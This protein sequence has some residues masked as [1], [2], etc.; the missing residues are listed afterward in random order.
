[1]AATAFGD[2][3]SGFSFDAIFTMD[4]GSNPSSR[5]TSSIGFPGE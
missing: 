5:A 1:M 3:P 4:A 2:G